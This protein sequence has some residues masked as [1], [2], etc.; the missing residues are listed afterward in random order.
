MT[1]AAEQNRQ[2]GRFQRLVQQAKADHQVTQAEASAL[3][4]LARRGGVQPAELSLLRELA[5]SPLLAQSARPGLVSQ[6]DTLMPVGAPTARLGAILNRVDPNTRR[7]QL[8]SLLDRS[9][10]PVRGGPKTFVVRDGGRRPYLAAI[11]TAQVISGLV[12]SLPGANPAEAAKIRRYLGEQLTALERPVG[13]GGLKVAGLTRKGLAVTSDSALGH[14]AI[15]INQSAVALKAVARVALL[16]GPENQALARRAHTL[17]GRMAIELKA[18]LDVAYRSRGQLQYG[19]RATRHGPVAFRPEDGDH[20]KTT[21]DALTTLPLYGERFKPAIAR[22]V[23]RLP[24]IRF[25]GPEDLAGDAGRLLT[26]EFAQF[27]AKARAAISGGV[28]RREQTQL[29]SFA[30]RDGLLTAGEKAMLRRA[31]VNLG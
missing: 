9:V 22:I 25:V 15:A 4:A 26:S 18:D 21:L 6:V 27:Q 24:A 31:G 19:L 16:Q 13:A 28:S 17:G 14:G 5:R 11:T 7:A 23:Q 8:L 3:V 30:R 12:A 29:L 2:V 10:N 1:T 20:L